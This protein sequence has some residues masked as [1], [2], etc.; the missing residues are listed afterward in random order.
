MKIYKIRSKKSGLFSNGLY[1]CISNDLYICNSTG[2]YSPFDEFGFDNFG[3]CWNFGFD[4]FGKCW[5]SIKNVKLYLAMLEKI[6]A[7]VE[8]VEYDLVESKVILVKDI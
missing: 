8:V 1:I 7:N 5:N 4:N 3:K 2:Y 6:L